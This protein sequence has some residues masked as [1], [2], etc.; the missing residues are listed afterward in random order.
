MRRPLSRPAFTLIELLVVIAIIA[1]LIGLL[2]PAVQ[3]V[4]EAAA[5][6]SCQNNLKQ[7]GLAAHNFEST[8]GKLPPG[9]LGPHP[10]LIKP[11]G[12]DG[13]TNYGYEGQHVG[14]LAILLP[15]IEQD[16]LARQ[17]L[18]GLPSDYLDVNKAYAPWFTF[19]STYAPAFTRIKGFVCPSDSPESSPNIMFSLHVYARPMGGFTLNGGYID[20][21]SFPLGRSS[22]VGVAGY[23]GNFPTSPDVQGL[24]TNRSAVTLAQATGADGT[25][26]TLMFGEYLAW[27]DIGSRDFSAAWIG[28]GALPT[29]W[30]MPTGSASDWPHFSSKHSGVVQFCMGDGSVK[31]LRKGFGT[32]GT[33]WATFVF[34][35]GY[36]DGQVVDTAQVMN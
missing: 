9:Y 21:A 4:R 32:S 23:A 17:L 24:L 8:T 20:N 15:Y 11:Q 22:Y 30:G 6:M 2:L 19:S 10:N 29:A 7:I 26:N 36:R 5:R 35:S 25:S 14:V 27:K 16:N 33:Q 34:M 31:S 18:A 28:A 13:T 1:I 3:K 12:N